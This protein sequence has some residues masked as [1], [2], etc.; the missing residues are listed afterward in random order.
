[1]MTPRSL[2]QDTI[3]QEMAAMGMVGHHDPAVVEAWMRLERDTLDSLDRARLRREV[4]LAV[5]C[6]DCAGPADNVELAESYGLEV[7]HG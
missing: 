6:A 4:L 2:Y 5:A 3:R 1:M 7:T